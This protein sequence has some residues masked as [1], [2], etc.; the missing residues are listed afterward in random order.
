[1]PDAIGNVALRNQNS[2]QAHINLRE[3]LRFLEIDDNTRSALADI[4]PVIAQALPS[5][6]E[7]FY[8]HVVQWPHLAEKF[9][10]HSRMDYA[11]KGQEQHWLRLFSGRFDDEY[12]ASVRKIGLVHSRVGLEPGWYIGAYAF[13][14]NRLYQYAVRVYQSRFNPQKAQEKIGQL[15]R[16]INQCVM[17]DMDIAI[18]VYLEE[19]KRVYEERLAGLGKN[20]EHSVGAI[21]HGVSAAATELEASASALSAIATEASA[22]ANN[23]SAAVEESASNIQSVSSATEEISASISGVSGMAHESFDSSCKAADAATQS[24]DMMQELKQSID[25]IGDVAGLISEIAE[26]T[27]LLALNATI[28]AA[29]AGEAGKG[30]SVVAAEVKS[31]ASETSRATE[32][33]KR[34][35]ADIVNKSQS[36][37]N[38]LQ[39]VR[40]IIDNGQALSRDTAD[41]VEQQKAAIAEIA[42]N[43]ETSSDVTREININIQNISTTASE[44]GHSAIQVLEAV[45]DLARQGTI[46]QDAVSNFMQELH[47]GAA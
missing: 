23:V 26:Q 13:T 31:L 6:L 27:N 17:L 2:G 46:L 40:N 33:I 35:V 4:Q 15:M 9:L 3:R 44:T 7:E 25:K 21:V 47:T 45:Q 32:D 34:Q 39:S 24:F 11:R 30:F 18:S 22:N 43:I 37:I 8:H 16:A 19:N 29:R 5:I 42:R 38:A 1:M 20:F 12:V 10:D 28:E 41:A 36:A 14:L